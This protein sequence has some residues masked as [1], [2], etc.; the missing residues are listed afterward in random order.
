M[1]VVSDDMLKLLVNHVKSSKYASRVIGFQ[2][3][4]YEWFQWEWMRSRMDVSTPMKTAFRRWLTQ[5]YRDDASLQKAWHD[6]SVNLSSAEIPSTEKRSATLDGVFRNPK[7]SQDAIDYARF[8]NELI[9]D[10]LARQAGTIKKAAGTPTLVGSFYGYITTMIDGPSRQSSGHLALHKLVSSKQIDYLLAPSDGYIFDREIGGTGG[11]MSTIDTCRLNGVMW[12]NQP[13]FRTHW[14]ADDMARTET[15][16][17]DVELHM[18]EFAMNLTAHTAQQFLDFSQG[19]SLGDRRFGQM[20]AQQ[21][22]IYQFAQSLELEPD[23]NQMAVVISE[24][25]ADYVGTQQVMMD[26]GLVYHQRPLY[27]RT[28]MPFTNCLT[29]DIEKLAARNYKIWVFPNIFHLTPEEQKLIKSVCMKKGNVVVFVYAPGYVAASPAAA[30]IG[31]FTGIAVQPVTL[32]DARVTITADKTAYIHESSDI[33]YGHSPKFP[34]SPLFAVADSKATVLGRYSDG[35]VGLAA[36]NVDGCHVVYSGVGM[37]P[38]AL[39]RDLGRLSRSHVYLS[40]NDAV[41]ASHHFIAVH[42][43][44]TGV[45]HISLP[46]RCDVYEL[47]SRRTVA[48]NRN[49]FAV[50]MEAFTTKLFYLG[51]AARAEAFFR[52]SKR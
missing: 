6:T 4:P 38:P 34:W 12:V 17:D 16:V 24:T 33:R 52:S 8:Y 35:H 44:S 26:G 37:L 30:N 2:L 49:T 42:A 25:A 43:R 1:V 47:T 27:Y 21:E 29:S 3:S 14:A 28:G 5:H 40:T 15:I 41:Y 48:R 9:A 46:R 23:I 50:S 10:V 11:Y 22:A 36:R 31:Q 18:R 19:Y 7:T 39:L 51:D 32:T 20:L 45:K 13:D